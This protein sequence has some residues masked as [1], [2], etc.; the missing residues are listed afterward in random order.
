[1]TQRLLVKLNDEIT[2][3][4]RQNKRPQVRI[5]AIRIIAGNF[6]SFGIEL[7][8]SFNSRTGRFH[9]D[10]RILD[11]GKSEPHDRGVVRGGD[12]GPDQTVL[13]GVCIDG[14]V[15]GS[16]YLVL[17][18]ERQPARFGSCLD[19]V[20]LWN[21][22]YVAVVAHPFGRLM[23][24][25]KAGNVSVLVFVRDDTQLVLTGLRRPIGHAEG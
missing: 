21:N 15:I 8:H 10:R 20:Q 17:M 22:G 2:P 24:S 4:V 13:V 3:E 7:N 5:H 12:L 1:M 25:D 6:I 14:I 11:G 9:E 23:G 16:C 19:G 18:R